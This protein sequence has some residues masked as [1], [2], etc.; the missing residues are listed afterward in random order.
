MKVEDLSMAELNFWAGRALGLPVVLQGDEVRLIG[1]IP[2]ECEPHLGPYISDQRPLDFVGDPALGHVVIEWIGF[3]LTRPTTHQRER[4]WWAVTDWRGE[5][6]AHVWQG[7][8]SACG[9]TV[10]LAVM[11]ALVEATFGAS[12]ELV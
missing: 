11:R 6:R 3:N 10:S 9:S 8:V 12:I 1:P 2:A 5:N 4:R 7:P